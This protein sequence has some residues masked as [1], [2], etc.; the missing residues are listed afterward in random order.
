MTGVCLGFFIPR[1]GLPISSFTHM[2]IFA[3]GSGMTIIP[4]MKSITVDQQ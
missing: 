1:A 3:L 4:L 2:G